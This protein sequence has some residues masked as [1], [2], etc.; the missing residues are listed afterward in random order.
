MDAKRERDIARAL[1]LAIAQ[2]RARAGYT[3]DQV[4]EA[5]GLGSEAVSRIERGV[6]MP[7][8]PRLVEFAELFQCPAGRLIQKGSDL[9]SDST[10]LIEALASSLNR[11]DRKF[12]LE[13]VELTSDH[14]AK[15]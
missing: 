11:K 1:G 5:L 7:T 14:L 2:E 12:L 6:V 9:P 8:V 10:R 3:Q 15:K 13:L 4:A